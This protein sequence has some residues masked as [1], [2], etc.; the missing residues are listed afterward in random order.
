MKIEDLY[1]RRDRIEH[2]ARHEVSV[3]EVEEAVFEDRRGCIYRIGPAKRN[4]EETVY[5]HYGRTV[6]GRYLMVVLI[7]GGGGVAM[8]VTARDMEPGERKSKYE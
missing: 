6:D 5:E 1:W 8:P 2:I 7:Y 4:A 3:A